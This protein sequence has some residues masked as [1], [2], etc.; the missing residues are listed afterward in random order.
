MF[1]EIPSL[2]KFIVCSQAYPLATEWKGR[3]QLALS[4][5]EE[6]RPVLNFAPMTDAVTKPAE[7]IKREVFELRAEIHYALN[8]RKNDED[9]ILRVRWGSAEVTTKKKTVL[10]KLYFY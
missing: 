5:K 7:V 4:M 10:M 8:L 1:N 9:Y 3:V 6:L 2:G